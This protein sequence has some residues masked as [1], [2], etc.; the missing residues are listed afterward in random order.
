MT[1]TAIGVLAVLIAAETVIP[2]KSMLH[3]AIQMSVNDAPFI[4]KPKLNEVPLAIVPG[5]C[6]AETALRSAT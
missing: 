3:D 2:C 4:V 5:V 6:E 1:Y